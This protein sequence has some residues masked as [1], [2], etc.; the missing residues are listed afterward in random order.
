MREMKW[1]NG[2]NPSCSKREWGD[3]PQGTFVLEIAPSFTALG[4]L[5]GRPRTQGRQGSDC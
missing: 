1:K 3:L 2:T 5:T 4:Y